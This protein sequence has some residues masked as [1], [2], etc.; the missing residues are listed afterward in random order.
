MNME[1]NKMAGALLGSL[2]GVMGLGMFSDVL[3]APDHMKKPG[4]DL[5]AAEAGGGKAEAAKP[6]GEPF[7]VLLAKA[8]AKK[9]ESLVKPCMACH[10]FTK[11]GV[12]K[13][14]P[15]LYGVV[16]RPKA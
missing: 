14:G 9:G 13:V 10:D 12:S 16:G 1:I 6:A 4:Y 8:D 2:L 11:P 3:Y 7:P 5:P 15:P